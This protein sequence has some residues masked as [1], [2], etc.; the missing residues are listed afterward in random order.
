MATTQFKRGKGWVKD[1]PDFRDNGPDTAKI[2]QGQKTRGVKTSVSELL[3][4]LQKQNKKKLPKSTKITLPPKTDL[5]K[6]C[7]P[8][9]DQGDIGSCTAHAGTALYEYFERRAYGKH[10][11]A[12]RLFLYKV[13]RNL[14]GWQG[15][16]G[17]ELR[18][19]MGAMALFGLVPEKY[20][21][22]N[23]YDFN[24]EPEA[25]HYS[26]AQNYQ[27]LV[28]YRLDGIGVNKD[29]LLR[30]IK[31]HLHLGLPSIFGFTC[32]SSLDEDEVTETGKIP[33]PGDKEKTDGGHAVMAVGYD[34]NIIIENPLSPKIKTKGAILIRNSWGKTWGHNG[35]GWLPY[36]FVKRGI[37]DDWWTMIKGEWVETEE[38][39][40]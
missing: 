31:E 2:T 37:A 40:M 39:G 22:Y 29:T 7:S 17:A 32:Y 4:R 26:F 38:F 35:Y 25:F 1:Y 10:V 14:L 28:Y 8:I 34:D 19:T 12:S 36:E 16:D 23:E 21:P 5:R 15:D 3:L 27:A 13:T 33:F 24:K 30:R 20:W 9:D 18:T 11:D 6:W